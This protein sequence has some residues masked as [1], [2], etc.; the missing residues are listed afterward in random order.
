MS[1]RYKLLLPLLATAVLMIAYLYTVWMPQALEDARADNLTRVQRHLDSV[2][3]G[4]IPALAS[5]QLDA[6][7]DNLSAL[8]ER[9]REWIDIALVDVRGRQVYPLVGS[10]R[11]ME[12]VDAGSER[13]I[14]ERRIVFL[15]AP[16][17]TLRV[18]VDFA[19]S[20]EHD[21]QQYRELVLMLGIMLLIFLAM[22]WATLEYAV[23]RPLHVLAEAS[24]ELARRNFAV[25]L[26]TPTGDE[27]G[28]LI[29]AF[30]AMRT[31]LRHYQ[32]DLLGEIEQRRQSGLEMARLNA[33]IAERARDLRA[34]TDAVGDGIVRLDAQG[35]VSFWNPGAERFFGLPAAQALGMDF[36]AR[37]VPG[38]TVPVAKAAF[39][40]FAQSGEGPILGRTV[41]VAARRADGSEFAAEL[42][43]SPLSTEQG[44]QAVGVVR[45][46]TERQRIAGE[47]DRHRHHLAELVEERTRELAA[48]NHALNDALALVQRTQREL[49]ESEKQASL[50]RLVAGFAHEINTPI[51]VA[52]GASSLALEEARLL[53]P[54]LDA[55]EVDERVLRAAIER[56]AEASG[57]VF[58]N[59][60]RAADLVG[61]FKRTSVDQTRGESRLYN[62]R[63]TIDDAVA[64]LHDVIKRTPVAVRVEVPE[65]IELYGQ[66]GALGQIVTNLVLNAIRHG[67]ADGARA[68]E[69][70]I[71]GDQTAGEIELSI[72]DDGAGMDE[73]TRARAF[74]PFFTTARGSGGTGLG[75]FICH[76]LATAELHGSLRCDSAAGEG[77][78]FSLRFPA[79]VVH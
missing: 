74:E 78:R 44:W 64:S 1:L 46:I 33:E 56:I 72:S 67:Y 29:G 25:K 32:S 3:E 34:I 54:L 53:L 22:L 24:G 42:T 23:R 77:T 4:L 63:E 49:I 7:Y 39:A 12:A 21:R 50:G 76:N 13:Q 2:V 14:V 28:K 11:N 55:D 15:D 37:M 57:L 41:E 36:H 52:V 59:L 51:G 31:D 8:R 43:I 68:G 5:G 16:L 65:D 75:L 61:R 66:P 73:A 40:H 26:P 38:R 60:S 18:L 79:S 71:A 58:A 19:E 20:A 27:V 35:R 6:I 30:D 48:R 9:N 69:V 17:G 10:S 62:L 70:L 47:L 45:D